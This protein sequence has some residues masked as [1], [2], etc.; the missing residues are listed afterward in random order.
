VNNQF[1]PLAEGEVI[2][3]NENAQLPIGHHM[4]KVKDLTDAIEQQLASAAGGTGTGPS[5]LL[6]EAGVECEVL[7]FASNAWQKG[8]LRLCL[9]FAPDDGDGSFGQVATSTPSTPDRAV[10]A[11]GANTAPAATST[12]TADNTSH[13]LATEEPKISNGTG[14]NVAA[15]ATGATIATVAEAVTPAEPIAAAVATQEPST[16]II[17]T[18]TAPMADAVL[19]PE[20]ESTTTSHDRDLEEITIDFERGNGDRGVVL[21][22]SASMDLDLTDT[23]MD[24]DYIDFEMSGLPEAADLNELISQ[25]ENSGLLIDEVWNESHQPNWPGIHS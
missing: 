18:P 8:R 4:F 5:N 10:P 14:A 11:T 12:T 16:P 25:P 15:I 1:A 23:G 13:K 2:S 22:S 19:L 7:R 9:E 20:E 24:N 21:S 17:A 6:T 3:V